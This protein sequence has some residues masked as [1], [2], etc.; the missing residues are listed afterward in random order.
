VM[1]AAASTKILPSFLTPPGEYSTALI[2]GEEIA[3]LQPVLGT[4]DT[5]PPEDETA[6][7]SPD[8]QQ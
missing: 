2:L 7:G 5:Q 1:I 3:N 8:V 4:Q 6:A